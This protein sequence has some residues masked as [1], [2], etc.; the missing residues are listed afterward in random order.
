MIWGAWGRAP[1]HNLLIL[2]SGRFA[3]FAAF[4]RASFLLSSLAADSSAHL[5]IGL[6]HTIRAVA[7]YSQFCL[8]ESVKPR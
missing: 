8:F 7:K 3:I 2:N 1:Q 5:S 4:R 6:R